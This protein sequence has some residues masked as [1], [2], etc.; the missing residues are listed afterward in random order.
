MTYHLGT[1]RDLVTRLRSDSRC[2]NVKVIVGGYVFQERPDLW[3]F[4]GADG[5]AGDAAAA[6]TLGNSL[7]NG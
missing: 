7:V 1:A 5:A 2:A 6:V 4:L 3:R